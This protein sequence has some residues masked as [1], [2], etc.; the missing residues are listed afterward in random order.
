MNNHIVN[1]LYAF[2]VYLLACKIYNNICLL[3]LKI[4]YQNINY[5]VN[6]ITMDVFCRLTVLKVSISIDNK[7]SLY[8]PYFY[9]F[10]TM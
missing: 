3:K 7:V 6:K 4:M 9:L 10:Y 2:I 5:S 1:Q 8:I